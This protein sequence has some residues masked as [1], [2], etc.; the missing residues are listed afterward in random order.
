LNCDDISSKNFIVIGADPHGFD[1]DND[2]KGCDDPDD[3]GGGGGTTSGGGGGPTSGGGGGTTITETGKVIINTNTV[4]QGGAVVIQD[5]TGVLAATPSCNA[6]TNTLSL[7]PSTM[8]KDGMRVIAVLAP[9]HLIDGTVLM[10]LPTSAIQIVAAHI[11]GGEV[12][13]SITVNKKMVSNL[14]GGKALY[15][16]DLNGVMSGITPKV[17]KQATLNNNINAILLWNN[18]GGNVNF[19]ADNTLALNI[20]SHR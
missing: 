15:S 16:V 9:C 3:G 14:G 11:A 5:L 8:L 6:I 4:T 18:A 19:N 13:S 2:G 20:I 7:G 12:T 10:N 1:G 17:G